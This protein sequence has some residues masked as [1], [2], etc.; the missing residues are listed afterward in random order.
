MTN[1][2]HK[3]VRS[4]LN[5]EKFMFWVTSNCTKQ[6]HSIQR[7]LVD[8]SGNRRTVAVTV[9]RISNRE[10]GVLRTFDLKMFYVLLR[11]WQEVGR[12]TDGPVPF[13]IHDLANRLNLSWSGRT[14]TMLKGSLERLRFIPI[15]WENSYFDKETQVTENVL[16]GFTILSHLTL[17]DRTKGKGAPTSK[18]CFQFD[19][20]ILRNL[21]QNY[22][23]PLRLNEML[24][25]NSELALML[26]TRLDLWMSGTT[27]FEK[28][29][30]NLITELGLN[31]ENYKYQSQRKRLLAAPVAE[32][33]GKALST[34]VIRRAEI[35]PTVDGSDHKLVI[36]KSARHSDEPILPSVVDGS[37]EQR[38]ASRGVSVG[39]ARKL[40][41]AHA[42]EEI[43]RQL[44]HFDWLSTKQRRPK[45]PGGW[46]KHAI[47]RKYA[48]PDEMRHR[49]DTVAYAED[50]TQAVEASAQLAVEEVEQQ[51]M[52]RQ[53]QA[54]APDLW[55]A[56]LK[57]LSRAG[58]SNA[59]MAVLAQL[60][61]IQRN[62][63]E[64][65][66]EAPT[67]FEIDFVRENHSDKLFQAFTDE[68][69]TEPTIRFELAA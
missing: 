49:K 31:P 11:H 12:P 69:G 37:L 16:N 48:L 58:M 2:S 10:V 4:E 67:R 59:A 61:V 39:V 44:A 17:H 9:G 51:L 57:R 42:P 43:E 54:T 6:S 33:E 14:S 21:Q 28:T 23:K 64:I 26:Y 62:G 7:T 47:E 65:V 53:S 63:N 36:E 29:L 60:V 50:Y 22:S 68:L 34:G 25:L 18:C 41:G 19:A 5:I 8:P 45:N 13:T 40:V 15:K 30:M 32:L 20:R 24:A 3:L 55:P 1:E 46:L 66:L 52:L 27:V 56:V 35:V 38:L